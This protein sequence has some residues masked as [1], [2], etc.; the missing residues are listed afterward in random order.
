[1]KTLPQC[2]AEVYS[3]TTAD[4]ETYNNEASVWTSC[5]D[6]KLGTF[7][8]L[9]S[10]SPSIPVAVLIMYSYDWHPTPGQHIWLYFCQLM[11]SSYLSYDSYCLYCVDACWFLPQ[12]QFEWRHATILW[13]LTSAVFS[14]QLDMEGHQTGSNTVS[15]SSAD[16]KSDTAKSVTTKIASSTHLH[17]PASP[18]VPVPTLLPKP[19]AIMHQQKKQL[20]Q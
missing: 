6:I 5:D 19:Q 9:S 11:R 7:I 10:H 14:N 2:L 13:T 20:P 3:I 4:I 16:T 12:V 1:M 17:S 18:R 15:K 8:C